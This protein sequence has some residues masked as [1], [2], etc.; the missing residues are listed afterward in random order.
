MPTVLDNAIGL[1]TTGILEGRPREAVTKHTG[2][3]YTQ[4]S[5]GVPDGQDGF[6]AFFDDFLARNPDR[7]IEFVR[8]WQDGRHAFIHAYQSLNG[9]EAKWVTTDFFDSDDE[10]RI[11]EHWDVITAYHDTNPSGRSAVDGPTEVTDLDKTDANKALVREMIE[12]CLMRGGDASRIDEFISREQYLQHN[13]EVPDG[14]EH[15][16]RLAQDPDRPLNYDRLV[17]LVGQGNFV[18]TLCEA[19]WEGA[20]YAQVD[21]FR[22]EDGKIV[23]HWDATEPVPAESVNAGKF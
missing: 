17:L 20:K 13:K 22:L 15:F 14:F 7:H 5:T 16:A 10:G 6:V 12:Q 1:Y 19:D 9:G 18:A 3:R 4:H 23:E 11:I 21:I 2:A 8:C